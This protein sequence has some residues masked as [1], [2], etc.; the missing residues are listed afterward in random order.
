MFTNQD[1]CDAGRGGL[2][3]AAGS[4]VYAIALKGLQ[5]GSSKTIVTHGS[6]QVY[7]CAGAG[8]GDRLIGSF[9]AKGA[10]KRGSCQG[11]A[12]PGKLFPGA[13]QVCIYAS[14]DKNAGGGFCFHGA[15][16]A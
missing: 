8:G 14:D 12:G 13:D 16:K 9:P 6:D 10:A 7:V 5:R 1:Q 15:K 4:G 2:Q 3:C 11:F